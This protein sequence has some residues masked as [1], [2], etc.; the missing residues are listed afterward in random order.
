MLTDLHSFT[1]Q[2][3]D[4]LIPEL[5]INET[6]ALKLEAA[7]AWNSQV[8]I[9]PISTKFWTRTG[10][11]SLAYSCLALTLPEGEGGVGCD[12]FHTVFKFL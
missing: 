1:I 3:I 12:S 11:V 2:S 9:I 10:W 7:A 8:P 4:T 6:S 5:I